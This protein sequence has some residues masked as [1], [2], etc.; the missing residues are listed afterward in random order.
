MQYRRQPAHELADVHH[1]L[2]LASSPT[3][4]R[5]EAETPRPAGCSTS[6]RY[7]SGSP[8]TAAAGG[9]SPDASLAVV[10]GN[11]QR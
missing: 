2:T 7:N 8:G 6:H 10:G 1:Y 4:D 9:A 11:V 5:P 3:S